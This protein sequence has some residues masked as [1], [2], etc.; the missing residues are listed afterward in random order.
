MVPT[1]LRSR[2]LTGSSS[3]VPFGSAAF[4]PGRLVHTNELIVR[5]ALA[6]CWPAHVGGSLVPLTGDCEERAQYVLVGEGY[7]VERSTVQAAEILDRR[8]AF[9]STKL[10][11]ARAQLADIRSEAAFASETAGD[12]EG[13]MV[14]IR[15]EYEET[16]LAPISEG[17]GAAKAT[18]DAGRSM[19]GAKEDDD[20][21]HANLMARLDDLE[22]AE[23]AAAGSRDIFQSD[24]LRRSKAGSFTPGRAT[25]AKGGGAC[26]AVAIRND[27]AGEEQEEE[28]EEE[29]DEEEDEEEE[30]EEEGEADEEEE[31]GRRATETWREEEEEG[32][33]GEGLGKSRGT[34]RHDMR[35]ATEG[36]AGGP[37]GEVSSEEWSDR[38]M[39]ME[40]WDPVGPEWRAG[41]L[42]MDGAGDASTAAPLREPQRPSP[43]E[44][45]SSRGPS[46]AQ[47][48]AFSGEVMEWSSARPSSTLLPPVPVAPDAAKPLSRFKMRMQH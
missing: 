6:H 1:P 19:Q 14:E 23:A 3:C 38:R 48:R 30:E 21:E 5:R 25:L 36:D 24:H 46:E 4:F 10:A 39:E 40:D 42:H 18:V 28:E 7:H 16:S 26:T 2:P 32:E 35:A 11:A 12:V 45:A 13:G 33:D 29:E 34:D 20:E 15:E 9:L 31:G 8:C 17:G 37:P 44:P 41:G 22:M 27:A 47:K 43:P